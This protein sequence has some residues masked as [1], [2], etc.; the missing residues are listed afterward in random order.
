M[1]FL[2][3][4]RLWQKKEGLRRASGYKAGRGITIAACVLMLAMTAAGC[5]KVKDPIPVDLSSGYMEELQYDA[6]GDN[7]TDVEDAAGS[8]AGEN[9]G[10]GTADGSADTDD[11]VKNDTP[12]GENGSAGDSTEDDAEKKG[13]NDSA[14]AQDESAQQTQNQSVG[15][16]QMEGDVLSVSQDSFVV[17][18]NETFTEDGASYMVG[19]APGYEDE[20]DKITVRVSKSCAFQYKT[21]KNGG[22]HP[23][24]VS[25]KE[26]SYTDLQE[27]LLVAIQGNW[28]DD[29]SFLAD[30]VV[31]SNFV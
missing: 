8:D 10:S 1:T 25:T 29:G 23:E 18:R 22:I 27:G 28:Q 5:G 24:D 16:A 19:A 2:Q 31:I 7:N 12:G 3:K 11:G 6:A 15:T 13:E 20:E 21:L 30:T 4:N 9:A 14:A 17:A 26:G